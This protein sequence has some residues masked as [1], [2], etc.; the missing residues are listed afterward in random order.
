MQLIGQQYRQQSAA[1]H[2]RTMDQ[3]AANTHAMTQGHQQR[4][5][6]SRASFDAHQQRMQGMWAQHDAHNAGWQAGQAASD[7]AQRRRINAIN[8]TA[9]ARDPSTGQVYRGVP[10][11]AGSYWVDPTNN[12]VVGAGTYADN[13]DVY[14]YQRG[15]NLDDNR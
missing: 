5:A 1:Q 4:M 8:E 14:R 3:I 13:P 6:N 2:Q 12:T 7:E 11:G 9:D 15:Q 10:S